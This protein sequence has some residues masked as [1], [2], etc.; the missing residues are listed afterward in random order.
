MAPDSMDLVSVVS[1]D[2]G[3]WIRRQVFEHSASSATL[4]SSPSSSDIDFTAL[5]RALSSA[6]SLPPPSPPAVPYA[7]YTAILSAH[8][9]LPPATADLIVEALETNAPCAFVLCNDT[10]NL[11]PGRQ[12]DYRGLLIPVPELIAFMLLH[13]ASA[14]ASRYRETADS[15][16]PALDAAAAVMDD[17]AAADGDTPRPA[18]DAEQ[19]VAVLQASQVAALNAALP[20]QSPV[21]H[22]P[23]RPFPQQALPPNSPPRTL[24]GAPA[25]MLTLNLSPLRPEAP[26]TARKK[27][28]GP[29]SPALNGTSAI[30]ASVSHSLQKETHLVASN[31]SDLLKAIAACYGDAGSGSNGTGGARRQEDDDDDDDEEENVDHRKDIL[32]AKAKA[33]GALT[34]SDGTTI[35]GGT[36]GGGGGR[37]A[38]KS[39]VMISRQ[40]LE[41]LSFLLTTAASTV[42]QQRL[43]IASIVPEWR[44]PAC[45]DS[46]PLPRL[47][48]LTTKALTTM[49]AD[50]SSGPVDTAE[51]RSL[52]RKTIIRR[53][54]PGTSVNPTDFPHG[55]EV[56][57][58]DC[59]EANVYLVCSL[60]RV[61]LIGCND[62][63]LFVGSCV[64]I[65]A[66]NCNRVRIHTIARVCRVTNC[67]DSDLYVCTNRRPQLVGDCRGIRFAPYNA[68]YPCIARD[69]AAVGVDPSR[70]TWNHFYRPATSLERSGDDD[71]K[72]SPAVVSELPPEKFLPFAVP[73]RA[74]DCGGEGSSA[75]AHDSDDDTSSLSGDGPSLRLLFRFEI[76][77][78]AEYATVIDERRLAVE[79]LTRGINALPAE[80]KLPLASDDEEDDEMSDLPTSPEP[81]SGSVTP[82]SGVSSPP[83]PPPVSMR[84]QAKHAIEERFRS[85]LISSG[86]M[87]QFSDLVRLSSPEVLEDAPPPSSSEEPGT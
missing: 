70:S 55:R 4:L 53:S 47:V 28:A 52:E 19:Q 33:R 36:A 1:P 87:R 84:E 78:P 82:P 48:E 85:W 86:N 61:S 63:T 69:L 41:N 16:W 26:V 23:H 34:G 38:E 32:E 46:F 68:I 8:A 65:S 11:A 60:G 14:N 20:A 21:S 51:I 18:D 58:T 6:S 25:E 29:P 50:P 79:A 49:S 72:L 15:V 7:A 45:T 43:P 10:D 13:V 75:T 59:S 35:N 67:F 81:P 42:C 30:V 66:M 2:G 37:G 56:R 80:I 27:S 39:D 3:L 76:P 5:A 57:I 44:D 40:M 71:I 17:G 12:V 54:V 31:I 22:S 73:V 74:E 64:S 9:H 24:S 83:A 62:C 77:L